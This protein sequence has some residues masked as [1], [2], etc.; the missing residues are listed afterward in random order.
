MPQ[1]CFTLCVMPY[2]GPGIWAWGKGERTTTFHIGK[3]RETLG[4]SV[5]LVWRCDFYLNCAKLSSVKGLSLSLSLF[6]SFFLSLFSFFLS[7]LSL[8]RLVQLSTITMEK[9]LYHQRHNYMVNVRNN[10]LASIEKV[11]CIVISKP[12]LVLPWKKSSFKEAFGFFLSICLA[13]APWYLHT[14]VNRNNPFCFSWR[15]LSKVS[16]SQLAFWPKLCWLQKA[17]IPGTFGS[18]GIWIS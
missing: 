5:L 15:Y 18:Q 11:F 13:I 14:W 8:S 6:L 7:F 2:C 9:I 16:S 1:D 4:S 3:G 10:S 17:W 12:F